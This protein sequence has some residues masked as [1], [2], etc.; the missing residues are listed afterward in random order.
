MELPASCDQ[1]PKLDSLPMPKKFALATVHSSSSDDSDDSDD[2][3]DDT[4]EVAY[5]KY[6]EERHERARAKIQAAV[7][8]LD[9]CIKRRN[10]KLELK[11]ARRLQERRLLECRDRKASSTKKMRRSLIG[12]EISVVNKCPLCVKLF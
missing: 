10:R 9:R 12:L 3:S 7:D 5:R 4:R 1:S 6:W 11:K 2:S 8:S